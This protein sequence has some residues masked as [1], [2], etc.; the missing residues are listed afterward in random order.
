MMADFDIAQSNAKM[1]PTTRGSVPVVA[2]PAQRQFLRACN[3]TEDP[4]LS[5]PAKKRESIVATDTT[6]AVDITNLSIARST[7]EHK[8]DSFTKHTHKCRRNNKLYSSVQASDYS[9]KEI[10]RNLKEMRNQ[11]VADY[12]LS[13]L[14]RAKRA[15]RYRYV[16]DGRSSAKKPLHAF[17]WD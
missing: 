8:L 16:A 1:L 10:S 13:S 12:N 14:E 2:C 5:D 6:R 7:I 9:M 17:E 15:V 3:K 4:I 11:H